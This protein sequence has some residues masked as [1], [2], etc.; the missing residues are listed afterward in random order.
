[1]RNVIFDMGNVLINYDPEHFVRRETSDPEDQALLL[2]HI[3][4]SPQWPM[5]D[6]GEMDEPELEALVLTA[7][8][9]RLHAAAHRLI[10]AWNEPMEPIPGMAELACECKAR[11]MGVYLLSNAS[12]R[13]TEYWPMIPGSAVFDGAV[14]SAL[15]RRVKPDPEIYRILL[16]RYRLRPE[17]CLFIDDIQKNVDGALAVGIPAVRF[18]G[19]VEALR[20]HIFGMA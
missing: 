8:P 14:V 2:R 10:F 4:H 17:D 15:E 19:D 6:G 13:Q 16:D 11:G 3:F 9:K 18:T 5:L 12:R 20:S 7:L 1:M